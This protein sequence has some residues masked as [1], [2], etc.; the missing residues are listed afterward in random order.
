MMWLNQRPTV[1]SGYEDAWFNIE[2]VSPWR[3]A[4]VQRLIAA[5]EVASDEYFNPVRPEDVAAKL[6]SL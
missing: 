5:A 3:A 4:G 1:D 2:I 6:R